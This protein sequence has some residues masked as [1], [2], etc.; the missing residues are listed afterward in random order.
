MTP[1]RKRLALRLVLSVTVTV[2][3]LVILVVATDL[4]FQQ[5][6]Q[7]HLRPGYFL[8]AALAYGGVNLSRALRFRTIHREIRS[9]PLGR[10]FQVAVI[11]GALNQLLPFRTGEASYVVLMRRV[12][13]TTVGRGVLVLLVSRV[14]DLLLVF[15]FALAFVFFVGDELQMEVGLAAAICGAVVVVSLAALALLR[16]GVRLLYRLL[17]RFAGESPSPRRAK[18][19]DRAARLV[20]EAEMFRDRAHFLSIFGLSAAMWAGL[21][22]TFY[23]LLNGFGFSIQAPDAVVGSIGA[24]L[25]NVLPVNGV[26]NAGS[27]E[28]GWTLGLLLV[29]FTRDAA[30]AAGIWAHVGILVLAIGYGFGGWVALG[31]TESARRH[32]ANRTRK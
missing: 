9:A 13:G 6:T 2:L 7:L 14:F 18:L 12:H 4:D 30:F 1:E 24:V 11:H 15:C 22:V 16:P 29:G 20:A 31:S 23:A 17:K 19:R 27:L 10:W 8:L 28:A 26:A 5:L 32:V 21:F 25:T 3:L